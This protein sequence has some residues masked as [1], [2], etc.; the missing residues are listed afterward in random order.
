MFAILAYHWS[1]STS[2]FP[3]IRQLLQL[4]LIILIYVYTA[5]RPGALV[6][7]ERKTKVLSKCPIDNYEEEMCND[8]D[9]D[10]SGDESD[11]ESDEDDTTDNAEPLS[12][13]EIMQCLC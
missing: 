6:Y 8:N 13:E 11:D 5:S 3:D 12:P 10:D 9:D 4:A 1:S 2:I 7:V